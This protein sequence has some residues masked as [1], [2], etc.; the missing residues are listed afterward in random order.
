MKKLKYL[1][2]LLISFNIYSQ[3]VYEIHPFNLEKIPELNSFYSPS[4]RTYEYNSEKLKRIFNETNSLPKVN[5]VNTKFYKE[6]FNSIFEIYGGKNIELKIITNINKKEC[7]IFLYRKGKVEHEIPYVNGKVNGVYKVFKDEGKPLVETNYKDGVRNGNRRFYAY[8]EER[9]I[10]GDCNNGQVVGKIKIINTEKND[11]CL[12]P[13]N[14]K[15]GV[16]EYYDKNS[17]LICEVHFVDENIVNGEVIDY[18]IT[19]KKKWLIRNHKMGKL[20]GKTECFDFNG[21]SKYVLNYKDGLPI[22]NHKEFYLNGGIYKE[23]LYDENG[24]KIGT[25]KTYDESGNL[26]SELQYLN[27]KINGIEKMYNNKILISTREYVDDKLN[28]SWKHWNRETKIIETESQMVDNKCMSIIFYFKNGKISKR[29]ENNTKNQPIRAEY[30]DKNGNLFYEEKYNSEKSSEGIHKYYFYDENEDY[31]LGNEDEFDKNG[32]K[33]REKNYMGNDDY[34]EIIYKNNGCNIKTIYKN[35]LT[36]TEYY[37]FGR[38][39]EIEE[40][41][42]I[43]K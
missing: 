10:E 34:V 16:I 28:G 29:F 5:S 32:F 4:E 14:Y 7:T 8:N 3:E 25:W 20:D 39:I 40:F 35:K 36:T 6:N 11:Y 43:D 12:Y 26:K 31:F 15:N 33:V 42:K 19:T 9:I 30:F 23:S 13:T 38:K 24:I 2:I 17:N 37:Y 27:G 21:N 41:K 18:N 22:G 1:I